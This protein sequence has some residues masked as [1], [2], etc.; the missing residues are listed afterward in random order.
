M[1]S[2]LPVALMEYSG[3]W[4]ASAGMCVGGRTVAARRAG[5]KGK[6]S[7]RPLCSWGAAIAANEQSYMLKWPITN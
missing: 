3:C 1:K 2:A 7:I 6:G 5:T 4:Q